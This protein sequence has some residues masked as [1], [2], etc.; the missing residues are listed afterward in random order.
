MAADSPRLRLGIAGLGADAAMILAGAV[1][2]PYVQLTFATD[3]RPEA[4]QRFASEFDAETSADFEAMCHSANVDAIYVCTENELHLDHVRLAA[5]HH[6]QVIVNKPMALSL[7][8]A[9]AMI[10]AAARA[11]VRLVVGHSVAM[12]PPILKMAELVACGEFGR[13]LMVHT[14]HYNEWMYRP[15]TEDELDR[16]RGGG[17]LFRQAPHQVDIVRLI[18]GRPVSSVR[19]LATFDN[20]RGGDASYSAFLEF[21]GGLPST[22]V[23]S[24]YSHFDMADVVYDSGPT[25]RPGFAQTRAEVGGF[26]SPAE[27]ADYK[28]SFF[29]G[30]SRWGKWADV[31]EDGR[32]RKPYGFTIASCEGA[33]I[34]QSPAG[35]IA[36]TD[37]GAREI[38]VARPIS[39]LCTE[40]DILYDAWIADRPV[41]YNDGQWG[42]ATLAAC[43]AMM[44]SADEGG[45]VR[46]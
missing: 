4:R 40:L 39:A 27:E 35:L 43:L 20:K 36:Y 46:L 23:Y 34:R 32:P 18:A 3:Q 2:R 10:E 7:A 8:G 37:A 38:E 31:K 17:V 44:R 22:L 42:R 21:E 24:G 26:G 28:R 12:A 13:L 29:Y 9:D 5:E 15:R 25:V 33:D 45:D 16:A 41:A 6:K 14:W 1:A 11:G 19:A 30:G